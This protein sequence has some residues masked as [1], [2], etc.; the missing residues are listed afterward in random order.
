[1][2]QG[3]LLPALPS[4]FSRLADLAAFKPH[5]VKGRK[6][7]GL[8][9]S[10]QQPP[11]SV[12][13]NLLATVAPRVGRICKV[14]PDDP[15]RP[16]DAYDVHA[17]YSCPTRPRGE[18]PSQSCGAV[19]VY[20][21]ISAP[22]GQLTVAHTLFGGGR[23]RVGPDWRACRQRGR[24][25]TGTIPGNFFGHTLKTAVQFDASLETLNLIPVS[26]RIGREE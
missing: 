23:R 10:I 22:C 11:D 4:P 17:G 12:R 9:L 16:D 15:Y 13:R 24:H 20:V 1:M 26:I 3:F 21:G 7:P 2:Q 6:L 18:A 5:G 19:V 8:F 14:Q 25:K